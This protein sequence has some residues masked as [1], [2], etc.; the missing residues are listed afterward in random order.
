MHI[1][2]GEDNLASN[3]T[4]VPVVEAATMRLYIIFRSDRGYFHQQRIICNECL[5]E[6]NDVRLRHV[7]ITQKLEIGYAYM[8]EPGENSDFTHDELL[9]TSQTTKPLIPAF[10]NN[11]RSRLVGELISSLVYV[12]NFTRYLPRCCNFI[13]QI[14]CT[15][16]A[17]AKNTMRDIETILEMLNIVSKA[18]QAIKR[19]NEHEDQ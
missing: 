5:P 7:S 11:I 13:G 12:D 1:L 19:E 18:I 10:K 15:I 4:A 17:L 8:A 16:R 2:Y 3:D 14:D 6:V 9:T